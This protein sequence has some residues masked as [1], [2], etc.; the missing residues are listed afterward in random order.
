MSNQRS[1]IGWRAL[2]GLAFCGAALGFTVPAIGTSLAQQERQQPPVRLLPAPRIPPSEAQPESTGTTPLP[3]VPAQ[4]KPL[5]AIRAEQKMIRRLHESH[6]G[7][8][9]RVGAPA[10]TDVPAEGAHPTLEGSTQGSPKETGSGGTQPKA[11]TE[12]RKTGGTPFKPTPPTS[13]TP[14]H[15]TTPA[16]APATTSTPTNQPPKR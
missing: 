14:A 12:P 9:P 1:Q 8:A 15:S 16:P 13:T 11:R 5:R 7:I 2:T 3:T 4:V 10:Q 6:V